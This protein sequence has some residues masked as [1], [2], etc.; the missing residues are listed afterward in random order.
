[1]IPT[2][3]PST[4][5]DQSL[6]ARFQQ[7]GDQKALS[8]LLMR[9]RALIQA[10][11]NRFGQPLA[12]EDFTQELY[13]VL[14][15][16]LSEPREIRNFSAWLKTLIHHRLCDQIRR[17]S[18]RER[19]R[20]DCQERPISYELTVDH[21][22]DRARLLQLAQ[23]Q[24]NAIEWECLYLRYFREMSYQEIADELGLTFKQVCGRLNRGLTKMRQGLAHGPH[25]TAIARPFAIAQGD[26][27]G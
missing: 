27:A 15:E 14:F 8:L 17:R 25:P 1:M 4:L 20:A 23:A 19:Y 9:H 22:L 13:L 24:V 21:A 5:S 3:S 26:G 6:L 18:S 16:A 12:S 7:Q 11:L 10:M 2:L